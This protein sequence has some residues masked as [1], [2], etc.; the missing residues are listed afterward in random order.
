MNITLY[1]NQ[2]NSKSVIGLLETSMELE[3]KINKKLTENKYEEKYIK[4]DNE[5]LKVFKRH[6][7]GINISLPLYQSFYIKKRD[8]KTFLKVI[9][10]SDS[11]AGAF[12]LIDNYEANR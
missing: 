6:N 10:E 1:K 3:R 9:G 4:I 8:N 5:K 7:F 12:S 11:I 2:V